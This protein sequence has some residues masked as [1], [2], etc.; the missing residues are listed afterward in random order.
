MPPKKTSIF[1]AFPT[2]F[3]W[4]DI[5]NLEEIG[6]GSFGCVFTAKQRNG[7]MVVVKKLLRQ[8]ERETRVCEGSPHSQFPS[9]QEHRGIESGM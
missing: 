9:S 6:R 8:H 5:A 4:D 2:Q 1:E 7:E 3:S